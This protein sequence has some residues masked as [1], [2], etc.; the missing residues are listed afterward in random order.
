MKITVN[1]KVLAIFRELVG[2]RV[3][4]I[5]VGIPTAQQTIAKALAKQHP[6]KIARDIAFHLTDWQSN[7]AFII[8]VIL[9]PERFTPE[10]IRSGVIQFIAHAPNHTAAAAKLGGFPVTDVFEIGALDGRDDT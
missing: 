9:F 5:L 2:E 10:E 1:Q 8:A 7:A 6:T 4:E 3:A